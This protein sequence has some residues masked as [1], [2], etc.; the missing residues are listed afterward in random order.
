MTGC[1]KKKKTIKPFFLLVSLN[2]IVIYSNNNYTNIGYV[3]GVNLLEKR[4]SKH[5]YDSINVYFNDDTKL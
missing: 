4:N 3:L 2:S 1:L 5:A